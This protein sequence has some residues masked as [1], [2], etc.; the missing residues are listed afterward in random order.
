MDMAG[1]VEQRNYASACL[2]CAKIRD[3]PHQTLPGD[4][5]Y[6]CP[7]CGE[8]VEAGY[9]HPRECIRCQTYKTLNEST[10]VEG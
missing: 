10:E 9:V 3:C 4:K 5:F 2:R 7:V 6:K 1:G 8:V